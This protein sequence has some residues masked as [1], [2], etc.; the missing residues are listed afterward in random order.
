MTKPESTIQREIMLAASEAGMTI[1]R[2]NTGFAWQG[3]RHNIA[4]ATVTLRSGATF[5]VKNGL[6]LLEYRPVEF[7]LCPGSSDLIGLRPVTIT[8]K[9]V[10]STLAQFVAI[11]CKSRSGRVTPEQLKFIEHVA[12]AGGLSVVARSPDDLW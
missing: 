6:L 3:K 4:G 5:K 1:W 12:K 7:G 2:N 8:N 10:G 9:H 11:E